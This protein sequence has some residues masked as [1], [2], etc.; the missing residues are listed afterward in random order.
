MKKE[1]H[2]D[3]FG[4]G[5]FTVVFINFKI[6]Q[7]LFAKDHGYLGIFAL[8][9]TLIRIRRKTNLI[10]FEFECQ[11]ELRMFILLKQIALNNQNGILLVLRILLM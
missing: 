7:K 10:Y 5:N 8:L 9:N 1:C 11:R 2:L 6:L 4:T 3:R